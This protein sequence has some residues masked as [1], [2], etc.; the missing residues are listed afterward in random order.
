MKP[1]FLFFVWLCFAATLPAQDVPKTIL[2]KVVKPGSNKQSFLFGTFHEVSPSFFD[3]LSTATNKLKQSEIL[4]VEESIATFQQ[5]VPGK[6]PEWN[7][8][9]WK[10]LLSQEQ[11]KLFTAFVQKAEDSSYYTLNPALLTLTTSRLYLS[12]FCSTDTAFTDLMDRHIEKI[13]V[14]SNKKVY[15][16]DIN[17]NL[18]LKKEA[19]N[20]TPAQDSLSA[21]YSIHFMKSMLDNDLSDC[22]II[23][24]Y[25]NFELN[26][27]LDL[28]IR[29]NTMYSTLLIERNNK[30]LKKMHHSFAENNCFVA[31]GFRHL[32]YRQ[33]LIKGLR[34]LGYSVTP[35]P[36]TLN[37][38]ANFYN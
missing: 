3:A 35:V 25:K 30:W 17:H 13:A 37:R 10:Q 9:K 15:S 28:D 8:S 6:P 7:L 12:N 27:E 22:E 34:D 21:S 29:E 36:I 38:Q 18:L 5:G 20:F 23:R 4:F 31:V 14:S 24:S 11:L 2:W 26:Y 16:L 33:G 32:F 19:E 1:T